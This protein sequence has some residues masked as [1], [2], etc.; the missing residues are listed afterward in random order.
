MEVFRSL[1]FIFIS[2]GSFIFSVA[3][4]NEVR[5]YMGDS[6][7]LPCRVDTKQCGQLHSVKWYKDANRVYVLSH[8]GQGR[9]EGDATERMTVEYTNESTGAVLKISPVEG[10][11]EATYKC[12]I[13]YLE[14]IE[15][16]DVVQIVKLKTLKKPENVK[17]FRSGDHTPLPNSTVIGPMEEEDEFDLICEASGGKPIP[18]V[19]WYNGTNEIQRAKYSANEIDNGVGT[20][21]SRLQLTLT[22]GDL[23]ARFECR[24]ESD[25][26]DEPIISWVRIDVNVSPTGMNLT[27]VENHVVQGTNVKL[28]CVVHGARPAAT[29][30]WANG[31]NSILE[32][33]LVQSTQDFPIT[34]K[35]RA[36]KDG[37]FTTISSLSF[38]ASHWEN[39][40][41]IYCYAENEVMKKNGEQELHSSLILDV[42][43][44]PVITVKPLKATINEST[45]MNVTSVFLQ[46][47]YF[48]NPQELKSAQWI[49]DG[50]NL[51]LSDTSK[52]VGGT[53]T[54]PP[55]YINNVTRED[56][57][58]YSC[59]LG[60]DIGTEIS[61]D[62]IFLSV[63]YAPDVEVIISPSTPVKSV[64]KSTVTLI[65]NVTSGNP[66][67]L[68]KVRWSLDGGIMK[69]LPECNYTNSDVNGTTESNGG[70]FCSLDPSIMSLQKV[71]ETFA[72]RYTCQGY[73]VAGW[74]PVSEPEELVVYYPPNATSL[75]FFPSK[76]IKGA[77]V[78]L[79]CSVEDPGRPDNVTYMWFRGSH[80]MTEITTPNYTIT[81]VRL[82]SRSNFT[83]IAV[84]EGGRSAPSTVFVNV[85]APPT[86]YNSLSTYH[87]VLYSSKHINLTCIVECYPE[88][89]IVWH[90]DGVK[91]D[92][93]HNPLYYVETHFLPPNLQKNDF[94][95]INST[96]IWN[97][98]AWPGG[99]LNKSAPN[100]I[101]TCQATSNKIGPG[102]SKDFEV[103]VDYPPEDIIVSPKIVNVVENQAPSP[104]KCHGSGRPILSYMWKKNYTS[105]PIAR[106]EDLVLGALTRA[107]SGEYIC[108]ASNKHG[109]RTTQAYI[110]VQYAPEC[111]IT[112][113]D[114]DGN[115][116]LVCTAQA[117]PSDVSFVWR[118]RELNETFIET[119]NIIQEGLKSFL[120]LDSSVDNFR[121]YLCYA[122]NSI[123]VGVPC[124]RDVAGNLSWW[125][126]LNQDK[127]II[128]IASIVAIVVVVIIICL[129]I[130]ILCRRKRADTKF[131]N[132]L[133][134]EER[135]NPDGHPSNISDQYHWPLQ[136]GVLVQINKMN[137]VNISRM[138]SGVT[139][140]KTTS[141]MRI[142][143]F[144]KYKKKKSKVYARLEKLKD[145]LSLNAG[146]ERIPSGITPSD[147]G[148]VTFKKVQSSSPIQRPTVIASRKRKKPGAAPNLSSIEDKPRLG[149]A[150]P[151]GGT[152]DPSNDPDKGFYENLPFHGMQN[153]PNKP[154][155]IIAPFTQGNSAQGFTS[156]TK[157]LISS[158][159][160]LNSNKSF[161]PIC[162]NSKDIKRHQ[163]FHGFQSTKSDPITFMNS[164]QIFYLAE[165][166]G[167]S[168]SR[169]VS[170]QQLRTMNCFPTPSVFNR[171]PSNFNRIS[172]FNTI[173]G[174]SMQNDKF[175]KNGLPL[176]MNPLSMTSNRVTGRNELKY[177]IRRTASGMNS[178]KEETPE[179][180]E[181]K[182][183]DKKPTN[184]KLHTIV[185]KRFGSLDIRKH[186]CYSPTFYSMRCKKHAKKRPIIVTL[187]RKCFSD[188]SLCDQNTETKK[189]VPTD[190]ST[191][192]IEITEDIEGSP[193]TDSIPI[194]APRCS[195][196][197][198]SE[199]VYA[200]ISN[201]FDV[202]HETDMNNASN[203]SSENS[204]NATNTTLTTEVVIHTNDEKTKKADLEVQTHQDKKSDDELIHKPKLVAMSPKSN[205]S[206]ITISPI[207][208]KNSPILKVSPNFIKP[209]TESPKGALS[210]QIKSK[211][212]LSPVQS[213][214]DNPNK[215]ILIST[216][217]SEKETTEQ[218]P[219]V[220]QMPILQPSNKWSPNIANANG[221][222][223]FYT[224]TTPHYKQHNVVPPQYSA[225]IPHQKHV[226]LLPK[227]LFQEQVQKSKSFSSKSKS[228]KHHFQI[229]LQKCHSF[230]FQ[231]AESY[232]QPIKNIHEENLMRN[233]Y[234]SD[235]PESSHRPRHTKKSKK[236]T[237]GPLV[238]R[239][240]SDYQENVH[241][242]EN[243]QNSVQLQYPQPMLGRSMLSLTNKPNGIVYADLDIPTTTSR[244]GSRESSP[245]TSKSQN[246]KP[247]TEYA[248]LQFNDIGQEIDV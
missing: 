92:I 38:K 83:C 247:K 110:N 61:E 127:L 78:T 239:G 145:F 195:R 87:G 102:I 72:G 60:N 88:C 22:R 192:S 215:T 55:L 84:N 10:E 112:T 26:L 52:Y 77:S 245:F 90:K 35:H 7:A 237:K 209:K 93:A 165:N 12:E 76:V 67:V 146:R 129:I 34:T 39:G 4:E 101:Y 138:T 173:S 62:S 16:C 218:F 212:K 21:I 213:P 152:A 123:G 141:V 139:P 241:F 206:F 108:E 175:P 201:S 100:S 168:Q 197:N 222:N 33:D 147:K 229:P 20:G 122:N 66:S 37:T 53:T 3:T 140:F 17:I 234:L 46:C 174:I 86:F 64:D 205:S 227:A 151:L 121:T 125:K 185:E 223:A 14:V 5:A 164:Q 13:T 45:Y 107:D 144:S 106:T 228:K 95:S 158:N 149:V 91:L 198:R 105:D 109:S 8:A 169:S 177:E 163:S 193:S 65:C 216:G 89:S 116:S 243:M 69:E 57:G 15:N 25:A 148:V 180:I 230:K 135:E 43:Y 207:A 235:Y 242:Q 188:V 208:L 202:K 186:K 137:N 48:A 217:E 156:S 244:K 136:P 155:S 29:V 115:P 203:T 18:K 27:G 75:R 200:N 143:T 190:D 119:N 99:S 74:G 130:I 233:G 160:A 114:R 134:M 97:M 133:E 220:P 85:F 178:S 68:Q 161:L 224:L 154:I 98:T 199:I 28:D 157:S 94:E 24:V 171:L 204:D 194:P 49:K 118:V 111:S 248:T 81:S 73:T 79:E 225:T 47:V 210:L 117:N 41:T 214:S 120:L 96:L 56:M 184:R 23:L 183:R 54:N 196:K 9:A 187:P 221:Q 58:E 82:Q 44:P 1:V 240:G 128:I 63:L 211:M 6:V 150:L 219:N 179:I 238:L 236:N 42:R 30:R 167:N 191:N 124:E 104:I 31:S 2:A 113:V 226:K 162:K 59:S 51:D 126:T 131:N 11:D 132:P 40:K 172:G 166:I 176:T 142:R 32:E 189:K 36:E 19:R 153:P 103:A 159:G 70:P 231:T 182:K 170:S 50:R 71:D 80:Q 232:F 181:P 246:S